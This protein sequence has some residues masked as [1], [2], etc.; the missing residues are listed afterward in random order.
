M[1]RFEYLEPASLDEVCTVLE[2]HGSQAKVIAGGTDL[3]VQMRKGTCLPSYIVSLKKIPGLNRMT[4]EEDGIHIG[5]TVTL[6]DAERFLHRYPEYGL[7]CQAIHS[8]GSCQIRNRATLAGNLCNASPAA[9][10]APALVALD[11]SVRIHGQQG[12]RVLSVG[13]FFTGPR[14]TILGPGEIVCEV[15]LPKPALPAGGVFL[16]QS[17]RPSVD[18]ATVNVALFAADEV[19]R[20]VLGAVAPTIVRATAAEQFI[21]EHGLSRQSAAQAARLAELAASPISDLRGS[22][23]YR[24]TLIRVLTE[25]ALLA[26]LAER[27]DIYDPHFHGS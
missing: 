15:I 3:L 22:R 5:A 25:R 23:E 16:K 11:A 27:G 8:V 17:R 6:S 9:D 19:L 24:L 20:I 2:T 13:Q 18:L 4:T 21:A 26:L 7:L 12:D 1:Q 14:K 10:T